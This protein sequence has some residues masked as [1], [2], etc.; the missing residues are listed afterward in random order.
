MHSEPR[1]ETAELG[2]TCSA[3]RTHRVAIPRPQLGC[4]ANWLARR[5]ACGLTGNNRF[6]YDADQANYLLASGDEG[7]R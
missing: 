6:A 3:K 7:T 4:D 5:R 1:E 2:E